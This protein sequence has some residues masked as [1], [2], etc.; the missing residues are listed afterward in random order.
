[1]ARTAG[2]LSCS[3]YDLCLVGELVRNRGTHK[4]ANLLDPLWVADT[5]TNGDQ[6]AWQ[7]GEFFNSFP[8]GNYRN[9]WYS[10]SP[11]ELCAIGIHGQW[12]YINTAKEIVI[13]K[14]SCQP[15]ADDDEL[16]RKT[17]DFFRGVSS[18]L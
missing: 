4:G 9:L 5:F 7:R 15:M 18:S 17:L 3:I 16:D 2:G 14:F 10:I 1:M 12:I 11:G 13:S 6:L 8:K